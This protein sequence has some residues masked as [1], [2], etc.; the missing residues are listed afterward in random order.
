MNGGEEHH[1]GAQAQLEDKR[2]IVYKF[3]EQ[4][5]KI[6]NARESR[7]SK[8]SSLRKTEKWKLASDYC[9]FL[10]YGDKELVI[11]QAR[12]HLKDTNFHV[13][14]NIPKLLYDSRKGQMKKL[15]KARGKG[16]TA[17]FSK[18]QPDKMF[19]NGKYIAPG[20]PIE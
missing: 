12:K 15:Q 4:Q 1:N 18:A 6:T 11:D 8:A 13:Y 9:S 7:I 20:E 5:L 19:I 2:E 17:Y 16:F 10:C 3:L 14:D